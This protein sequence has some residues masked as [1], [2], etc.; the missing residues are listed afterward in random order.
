[1]SDVYSTIS[2]INKKLDSLKSFLI[3]FLRREETIKDNILI[4]SGFILRKYSLRLDK[5]KIDD[6]KRLKDEFKSILEVENDI[7]YNLKDIEEELLRLE[8]EYTAYTEKKLHVSRIFKNYMANA[9]YL[10]RLVRIRI[11]EIIDFIEEETKLHRTKGTKVERKLT[12]MEKMANQIMKFIDLVEQINTK[13]Q[14]FDVETHYKEE[15]M[16]GRAMSKKE[17][18]QTKVKK[19]LIGSPKRKEGDLVAVFDCTATLVARLDSMSS[20]E[21]KNFFGA[22]GVQGEVNIVYFKTKLKPKACPIPQS[23]GLREYKF[24]K[25]T[26]IKLAA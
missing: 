9:F 18:K 2:D 15:R 16:Y 4:K 22:I 17:A 21:I 3:K 26:P 6:L 20:D 19:E 12:S 1:M 10:S 23:N 8:K 13:L 24:P 7:N 14:A 5:F 25:N 11:Q